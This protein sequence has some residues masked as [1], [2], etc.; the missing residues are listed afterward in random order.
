MKN[1]IEG[2]NKIIITNIFI[3]TKFH[4]KEKLEIKNLIKMIFEVVSC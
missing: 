3:L 4:Q 2:L 1:P